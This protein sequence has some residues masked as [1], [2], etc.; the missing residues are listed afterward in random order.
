M[1]RLIGLLLVPLVVGYIVNKRCDDIIIFY[2]KIPT[3][4]GHRQ[5]CSQNLKR[6]GPSP[7]LPNSKYVTV[8]GIGADRGGTGGV[9]VWS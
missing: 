6:G 7:F 3:Q 1:S 2:E 5:N 9:C 8:H 4:R